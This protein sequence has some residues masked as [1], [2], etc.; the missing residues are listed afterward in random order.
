[1]GASASRHEAAGGGRRRAVNR[2]RDRRS[3]RRR[4]STSRT[5]AVAREGLV[6]L[7]L[8]AHVLA[9]SRGPSQRFADVRILDA[10]N[11]QVPYLLERRDEPLSIDLSIVPVTTVRAPELKQTGGRQRSVYAVTLPFANLPPSR[12]VLETSA[13]VFQRT[14]RLGSST[15]PI[16][17]AATR[18]STCGRPRRG[19]TRRSDTAAPLTLPVTSG[20]GTDL[21]WSWTKGTMRRCRSPACGCCCRRTACGSIAP[22]RRHRCGSSTGANDLQSPQ[23][24]LALLAPHVMGAPAARRR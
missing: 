1:M 12:L 9:H 5:I 20:A 11:R 8:D 17:T 21:W 3:I 22:R 10:A 14:V 16:A 2:S 24:D 13:R 6:A 23:Y 7:P 19:G 18:G 15:P 4:F